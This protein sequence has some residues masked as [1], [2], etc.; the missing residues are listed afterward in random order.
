MEEL[1]KEIIEGYET[2]KELREV[3][4]YTLNKGKGTK[5]YCLD[6]IS[7]LRSQLLEIQNDIKYN[8]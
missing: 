4:P 7:V 3:T 2:L 8:M 6:R 1:L 5:K